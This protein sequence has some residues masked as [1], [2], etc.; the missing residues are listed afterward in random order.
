LLEGFNLFLSFTGVNE[1]IQSSGFEWLLSTLF[2]A[3]LFKTLQSRLGGSL[4]V[5]AVPRR[6]RGF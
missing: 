3:S 4:F 5:P 6:W 2:D 1:S